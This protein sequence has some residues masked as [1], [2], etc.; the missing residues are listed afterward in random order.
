[1]AEGEQQ[2]AGEPSSGLEPLENGHHQELGNQAI[3]ARSA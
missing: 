2:A 1:M 3:E